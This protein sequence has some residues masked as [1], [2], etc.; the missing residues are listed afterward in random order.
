MDRRRGWNL[1]TRILFVLGVVSLFGCAHH[2][3]TYVE[4]TGPSTATI[5]FINTTHNG[6][7]FPAIYKEAATCRARL[8]LAEIPEGAELSARIISGQLTSVTLLWS[9]RNV[10]SYC[11]MTWSFFPETNRSYRASIDVIGTQC[12][13]RFVEV[14]DAAEVRPPKEYRPRVWSRAWSNEGE[15]CQ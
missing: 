6:V 5:R 8:E 1:M 3:V 2:R 7:A 11:P 10:G 12:F 14:S 13:I 15:W 9:A 4:P